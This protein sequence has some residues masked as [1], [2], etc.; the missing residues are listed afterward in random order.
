[1][2]YAIVTG[3]T[4]GIG[5][6]IAE[7][8]L[9]E[10]FSIAICART[11]ADIEKTGSAWNE[12]YPHASILAYPADLGIKE[13]VIAFANH[14]L[15]NFPQ[16]DLLINNAGLY[17]PGQLADE[18]DGQLESLMAINMYSAYHLTR[19]V[20]PIMK[21]RRSGHIFNMCSVAGLK[22]YPNGGDYSITK[23]ALMGFSENLRM[24]LMADHIKVTTITPGATYTDSWAS[25]GIEESRF[26]KSNDV[27]DMVWAAYNLSAS[28]NVEN[29]IIRPLLGDI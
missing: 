20:L 14:V 8:L 4:K 15:S 23:Y 5:K 21:Q 10:G 3:A 13:E 11:K 19:R 26:M 27:A 2:P 7:K 6:A 29:I 1:M 18:P 9:T 24:E 25:T 22:A 16:I 12:K 17:F 28:A